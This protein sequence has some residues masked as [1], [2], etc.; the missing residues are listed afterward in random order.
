[1]PQPDLTDAELDQLFAAARPLPAA[2]RQAFVADVS[3]LLASEPERGP[4]ALHRAIQAAQVRYLPRDRH[5]APPWRVYRAS[6]RR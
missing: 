5:K 3:N 4:G 2:A 1:M 6:G